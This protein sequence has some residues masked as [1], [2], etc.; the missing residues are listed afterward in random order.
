MTEIMDKSY[1]I[2]EII[3]LAI[4][5][6]EDVS[7]L[8]LCTRLT[9]KKVN[10]EVSILEVAIDCFLTLLAIGLFIIEIFSAMPI[11][12]GFLRFRCF[13]KF[14][15]AYSLMVSHCQKRST[16]VSPGMDESA[17]LNGG[18]FKTY[19]DKVLHILK[20]CVT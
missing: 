11:I 16:H 6:I 1:I 7:K 2:I 9:T 15:F 18:V 8:A 10:N 13:M 5:V 19:K 12:I 17:R 4:M 20:C 3:L 14:P